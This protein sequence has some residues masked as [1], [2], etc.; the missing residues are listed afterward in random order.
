M[1]QITACQDSGATFRNYAYSSLNI[2]GR[3]CQHL[4]KGAPPLQTDEWLP[5]VY[6]VTANLKRFLL[7]T[8]HDVSGRCLHEQVYKFVYRFNRRHWESQLPYRLVNVA[9][10]HSR[11][12]HFKTIRR[13]HLRRHI[14]LI[15]IIRQS[16]LKI[17]FSQLSS[18]LQ[19][20]TLLV[21][22]PL[23]LLYL[24][25]QVDNRIYVTPALH[26]GEG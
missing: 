10:N 8:F 19:I 20:K 7:G 11:L 14:K 6:I 23:K 1:T 13:K 15:E 26:V 9:A 4:T 5:M 18:S 22:L 3:Y 25:C 16:Q 17:E 21:Q 12:S 2:V 24:V